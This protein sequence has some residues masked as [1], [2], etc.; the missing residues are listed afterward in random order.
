[1]D[2]KMSSETCRGG[3]SGRVRPS[4]TPSPAWATRWGVCVG[5]GR[6]LLSQPQDRETQAESQA[7]SGH[8]V[9]DS[10]LLRSLPYPVAPTQRTWEWLTVR[11]TIEVQWEVYIRQH[12]RKVPKEKIPRAFWPTLIP[13]WTEMNYSHIY[14]YLLYYHTHLKS[15][16]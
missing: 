5:R 2:T 1:M 15:V 13:R 7:H 3:E 8:R 16:N 6:M 9:P 10:L 11:M 14:L 12:R 4:C